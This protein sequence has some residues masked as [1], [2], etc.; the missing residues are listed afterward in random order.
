[1]NVTAVISF[2]AFHNF[3]INNNNNNNE[4]MIIVKTTMY[5]M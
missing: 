5:K 2:L 4:I 1:M 3:D